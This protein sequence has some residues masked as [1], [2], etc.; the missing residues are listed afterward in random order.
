MAGQLLIDRHRIIEN[1]NHVEVN[2]AIC[3]A[4]IR[5]QNE[6]GDLFMRLKFIAISMLLLSSQ[7]FAEMQWQTQKFPT[8][9]KQVDAGNPNDGDEGDWILYRCKA[10]GFPAMWK[11]FQEGVRM[12]IGFGTQPNTAIQGIPTTRG[13]WPIVW[14]GETKAGKFMADVAFARFNF[15][16]EGNFSESIAIFKIFANG[17]SCVVDSIDAGPKDNEKAKA[18]AIAARKKWTCQSEPQI[19]DLKG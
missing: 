7:A 12:N 11:M 6:I 13:D 17:A 9:C 2:C 19:L 14:G 5:L 1:H 18:L 3:D 10:A 16:S 15:G 8:N 4:V